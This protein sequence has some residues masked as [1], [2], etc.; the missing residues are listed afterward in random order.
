MKQSG[1]L[2]FIKTLPNFIQLISYIIAPYYKRV[3]TFPEILEK[4]IAVLFRKFHKVDECRQQYNGSVAFWA[5]K[6]FRAEVFPPERLS[7]NASCTW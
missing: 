4:R 5:E 6:V 7:Q 1:L 3:R 2:E